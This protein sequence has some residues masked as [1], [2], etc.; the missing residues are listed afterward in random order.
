MRLAATCLLSSSLIFAP[1]AGALLAE[2]FKPPAIPASGKNAEAFVPQ[3]WEINSQATGDLNKD[4]LPDL[5]L[6][7]ALS[8]AE[9]SDSYNDSWDLPRLLVILFKRKAGGYSRAAVSAKAI[10]CRGCGGVMGDP[11]DELSVTRGT[12]VIRHYGGS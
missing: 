10:M 11:F 2:D 12:V 9:K 7:L 1:L 5:V 6:A 8:A 4:K 3:G